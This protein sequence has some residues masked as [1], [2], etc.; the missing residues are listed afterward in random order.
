MK[1]IAAGALLAVLIV[2]VILWLAG[3]SLPHIGYLWWISF[4]L[5]AG[6]ACGFVAWKTWRMRKQH[7][8]FHYEGM[9]K[10]ALVIS[11]INTGYGLVQLITGRGLE[12]FDHLSFAQHRGLIA[13]TG[14]AVTLW[15]Q[16]L[17]LFDKIN[18][19]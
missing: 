18:G 16:C 3:I 10:T 5:S 8:V 1:R 11:T 15:L 12:V 6:I 13:S 9:V 7:R 19:S 17:F 14:L 2:S 4:I